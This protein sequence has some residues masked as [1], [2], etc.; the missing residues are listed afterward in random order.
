LVVEPGTV[1][2][3]PDIAVEEPGTVLEVERIAV[4]GLDLGGLDIVEGSEMHTALLQ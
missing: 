2:E 1:A 4:E 3:G